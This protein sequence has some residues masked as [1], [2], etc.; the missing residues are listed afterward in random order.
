MGT[1]QVFVLPDDVLVGS[2]GSRIFRRIRTGHQR[3]DEMEEI[4]AATFVLAAR[5]TFPDAVIELVHLSD[6][7]ATP[8]TMTP[9]KLENRR[10]ENQRVPRRDSEREVP[11]KA[12]VSQML[13]MPGVFH[14]R[15]HAGRHPAKKILEIFTGRRSSSGLEV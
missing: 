9:K 6:E 14:L 11:G 1:S 12:I 2:D 7:T 8:V 10:G 5:Q 13:R 3:T 15:R 4:G